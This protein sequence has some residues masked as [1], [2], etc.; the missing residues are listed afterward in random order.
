MKKIFNILLQDWY[1][2]FHVLFACLWTGAVAAVVLIFWMTD[3]NDSQAIILHSS[4]LIDRI[5]K[6][7]IIPSSVLCYVFGLILSWKSNWGFFKFKWLVFKLIVGTSLLLFGV[8]FLGPWVM[9]SDA[10]LE[11][12]DWNTY[13]IVQAKLGVSMTIQLV[14]ILLVIIVS[15]TKPWGRMN[16]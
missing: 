9:A 4:L 2:T 5:D 15:T 16:Y 12:G 7:I 14:I 13:Q 3:G 6:F 1:K 10:I 8:F 11:Q